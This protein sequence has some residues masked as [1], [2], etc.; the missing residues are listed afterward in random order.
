ME[1]EDYIRAE[2]ARGHHG[3]EGCGCDEVGFGCR[4]GHAAAAVDRHAVV[5]CG[6]RCGHAAVAVL[7][8][9]V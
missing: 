2:V 7:G 5:D 3:A 9:L 4:R 6:C 1:P 8:R